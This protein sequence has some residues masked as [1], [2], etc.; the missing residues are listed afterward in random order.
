MVFLI[1]IILI[2]YFSVKIFKSNQGTITEEEIDT[3]L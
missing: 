3:L 1:K 2:I